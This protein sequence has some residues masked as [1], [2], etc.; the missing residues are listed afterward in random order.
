MDLNPMLKVTVPF[1][2]SEN[3]LDKIFNWIYN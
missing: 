2:A 1:V 3:T